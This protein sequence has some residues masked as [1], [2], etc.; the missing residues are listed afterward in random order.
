MIFIVV[1]KCHSNAHDSQGTGNDQ[2]PP[3]ENV[4]PKKAIRTTTEIG[5]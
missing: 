3:N 5:T 4:D 1:H 2:S